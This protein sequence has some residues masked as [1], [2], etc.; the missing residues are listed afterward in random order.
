MRDGRRGAGPG[1]APALLIRDAAPADEAWLRPLWKARQRELGV[2][3]AVDWWRFWHRDNVGQHY[4]VVPELGLMHYRV[5]KDGSSTL[6]SLATTEAACG[7]GVGSEL[8][9]MLP[10][11]CRF[12]CNAD[13]PACQ[14]YERRG[15]V[16]LGRRARKNGGYVVEFEGW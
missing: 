16:A 10:R 4:L 1:E 15:F 11:P 6:I 3:A 5:R 12:I 13:N 14:W 2:W 9:A 7:R 8:V